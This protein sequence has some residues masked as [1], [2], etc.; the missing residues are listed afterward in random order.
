MKL[1]KRILYILSL[2][3]LYEVSK[4]VTEQI[5]ITLESND[6]VEQPCDYE[7]VCD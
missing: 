7:R 2:L 3:A 6:D 5:L 4:Y 1:I